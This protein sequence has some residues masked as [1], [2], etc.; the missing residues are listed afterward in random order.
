MRYLFRDLSFDVPDGMHDQS[1]IV[2]VEDEKVALTLARDVKD[3]ALKS[4]VD[5]A[6]REL[7]ASMN[8]YKLESR[9]EA[10]VGGKPALVLVQSAVSPEGKP[11]AQ[12]QAYVE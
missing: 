10:V 9:D 12:R 7:S 6:V 5:D 2:L 1:M 3:G 8:A 4:Y 11:V